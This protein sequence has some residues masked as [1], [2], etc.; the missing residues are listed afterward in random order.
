MI[1]VKKLTKTGVVGFGLYLPDWTI[2]IEEIAKVWQGNA[3]ILKSSLGLERKTVAQADE[4]SI[5]MAV[6]AALT[7]LKEVPIPLD[8]IGALFVG[9]ESHPY[10]VK[11]SGTIVG[12]ALGL[13]S[14]YFCVDLQFACKAATAG[15]Q[16][17]AA[18]IE[19]GL[20]KYGLV[21]GTDKA[22]AKPGDIL[23]YTA[24]SGAA[25][26]ILGPK[27]EA[28]ASL[29]YTYSF[30]SDTPDFWRRQGSKT[31]E[32][33]GRFTGEPSYFKHTESAT[34][35]LLNK[36][37]YKMSDFSH[38]VFHMPNA[39]FPKKAAMRLK[40]SPKQ[41]ETGFT[42][43]QI[44]N[45]YSASSLIGLIAVLEQA[46][47]GEKILLTSYGS[48]SGSDSF[49]F[50]MMRKPSKEKKELTGQIRKPGEIDYPTYLKAMGQL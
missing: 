3:K 42:V 39:K 43:S 49:I 24:A 18:M 16:I 48:G 36:T 4:D 37:G 1:K 26:F 10:A 9:S 32:H 47:K 31:P 15:I 17:A 34:K 7:A 23:E 38:V 35:A 44:G 2:E 30:S 13:G 20:I 11:P 33:L 8:E 50:T 14:E 28:G 46:K 19:A 41:L 6:Q 22:Q 25:A 40:V 21:I 45:P 29:D 12:E 27:K 5:T